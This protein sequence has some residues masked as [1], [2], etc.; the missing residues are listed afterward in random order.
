MDDADSRPAEAMPRLQELEVV[1]PAQ[2]RRAQDGEMMP[3]TR[4]QRDRA[5][6][7]FT[8]NN[9][10]PP[11]DHELDA[12]TEILQNAAL[13][14]QNAA[15]RGKLEKVIA[16]L[17]RLAERSEESIKTCRFESLNEAYRADA[18]NYRATAKD[19][20]AALALGQAEAKEEEHG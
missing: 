18:K 12:L 17:N 3:L 16:W 13:Q 15:L 7:F 10:P 9:F 4:Q 14:Q 2:S 19:L 1:T 11:Y 20:Q 5:R 8:D 6:E